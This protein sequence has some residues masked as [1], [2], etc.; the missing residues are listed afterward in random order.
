VNSKNSSSIYLEGDSFSDFDPRTYTYGNW[1][2]KNH[3]GFDGECKEI[4]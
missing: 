1:C 3:G 4:C 2:G